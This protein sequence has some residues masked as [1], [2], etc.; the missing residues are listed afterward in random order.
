MCQQSPAKSLR[1][2]KRITKF[3]EKK[4]FKEPTSTMPR[5]FSHHVLP[6]I[7]IP[8]STQNL[9]F[10]N[11]VTISISPTPSSE[12]VTVPD[13]CEHLI[14]QLRNMQIVLTH[15]DNTRDLFD[16]KNEQIQILSTI[17]SQLE[18]LL[19]PQMYQQ[20]NSTANISPATNYHQISPLS[21]VS[22]PSYIKGFSRRRNKLV[23][24][25]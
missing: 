12:S 17:V 23:L 8:P 10:S 4:F 16:Y 25:I 1:S 9:S 21:L 22:P 19:P 3:F 24:V 7:D 20:P 14:P 11:P 13:I 6:S 2:I 18:S 5:S 15:V